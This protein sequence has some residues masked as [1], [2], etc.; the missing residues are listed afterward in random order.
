MPNSEIHWLPLF[1]NDDIIKDVL[2]D[3]EEILE[4]TKDKT[5]INK[6]TIIENGTRT[7]KLRTTEF[8]SRNIPH[9]VSMGTCGMLITMK[10]LPTPNLLEMPSDW[11]SKKRLPR[12][13]YHICES[14]QQSRTCRPTTTYTTPISSSN[15]RN[16]YNP[17]NPCI[18]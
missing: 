15:R 7:V 1:I 5:V 3:H 12:K 17:I 16:T 8:D 2:K 4:I 14:S 11:A 6:D 9:I 10:G 18:E 13:S